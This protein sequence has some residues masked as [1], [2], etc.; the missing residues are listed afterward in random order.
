MKTV[1]K[2]VESK[3]WKKIA[4]DYLDYLSFRVRNDALTMEETN[5][6]AKTFIEN[7]TLKGTIND[8]ADYYGQSRENI[9]VVICRKLLSKPERRVYYSFNSFREIVPKGWMKKNKDDQSV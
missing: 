8:L 6:I 4:L 7:L 5:A 2:Q 1:E 3:V 9:K